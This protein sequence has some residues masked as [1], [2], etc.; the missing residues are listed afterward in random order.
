M[1]LY[2]QRAF[3]KAY[4]EAK[5]IAKETAEDYVILFIPNRISSQRFQ[6]FKADTF[7]RK[8]LKYDNIMCYLSHP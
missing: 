2:E 5:S 3:I 8:N 4:N 6:I 1:N 7:F